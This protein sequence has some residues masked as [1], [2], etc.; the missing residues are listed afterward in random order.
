MLKNLTDFDYETSN[1]IHVY[2]IVTIL[3]KTNI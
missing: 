3:K 2:K 1:T